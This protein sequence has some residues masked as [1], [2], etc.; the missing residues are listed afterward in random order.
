MNE[1][2]AENN[3]AASMITELLLRKL[4]RW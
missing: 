1:R 2:L 3:R 4:T